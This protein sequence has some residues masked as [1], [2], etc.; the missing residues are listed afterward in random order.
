MSHTRKP[1][2]TYSALVGQQARDRLLIVLVATLALVFG[3]GAVG[4][5]RVN[6]AYEI[7]S[8]V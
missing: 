6:R 2:P 4:L 3:V 8:R 5:E 1:D 7:A